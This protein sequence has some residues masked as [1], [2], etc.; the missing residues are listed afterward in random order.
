MRSRC[1]A[2][3]GTTPAIAVVRNNLGLIHKNRCEWDEAVGDLSAAL[4]LQRRLGLFVDSAHVLMNLGIV[5]QKSGD[6]PRALEDYQQ[7]EEIFL[8]VADHLRLT[9]VAIGQGNIA[10]LERRF[11]EAETLLLSALERARAHGAPRE[12]ALALEFLGE[13]DFDRGRSE[14]ALVRYAEALR[15]AQRVAP[16]GDLMVEI[17]RRRAE[18][19][20]A[21]A[22]F[23]E[24]ERA[25]ERAQ[26][27]ARKTDDRL[28]YA[29]T[30]RVAGDI[31][32][33]RGDRAEAVRAWTL[34][35]ASLRRCRERIEL[36]RVHLSLGARRRRPARGA[37]PVLPGRGPLFAA[38]VGALLARD[39]P[40][41]NCSAC[42]ARVSE[43]APA[44]PASLLGRRHR[45]PSLV[46]CSH[47]HAPGRDAG[48]AC[49]EH[50]AVGA[51]HRRDR[52]RQGAD[53]AHHPLALAARRP[54]VPGRELRR[55]AR[56]PGAAASC[57][58]TAR[59]PSPARTPRAWAWSKPPTAARCSSTRSASCR[60]TC[61]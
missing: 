14:A 57:S 32:W 41:P 46:A 54:A 45:A 4:A 23:D 34:A 59:A 24:A 58:D 17:E 12:E 38:A 15:I 11:L 10:R 42:S 40:R 36:G 35:A 53:R 25:R 7:A 55:V 30:E 47:A 3:S 49:G 61:R 56:R 8:Q 48:A 50:R 22:R 28:E 29:I 16:E 26:T 6:W 31:A 33:A 44:R 39:S 9:H 37:P 21:M 60:S 13:L 51:H 20:T 19:L 2:G 27:L 18:A 1:S 52:H 5:H 43:P